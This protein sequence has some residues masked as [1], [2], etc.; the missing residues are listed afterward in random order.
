MFAKTRRRFQRSE[1]QHINRITQDSMSR[2]PVFPHASRLFLSLLANFFRFLIQFRDRSCLFC[3]LLSLALCLAGV[4]PSLCKREK[5]KWLRGFKIDA[6]VSAVSSK[7]YTQENPVKEA[8]APWSALTPVSRARKPSERDVPFTLDRTPT[9]PK[10][11][12]G[13]TLQ[14][15]HQGSRRLGHVLLI[16]RG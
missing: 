7:C 9:A 5:V 1:R 4:S 6:D 12:C 2:Q 13:L 14:F 16:H 8:R 10:V 11:V 15:F 3:F